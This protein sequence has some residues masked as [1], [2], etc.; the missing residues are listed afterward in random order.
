[1]VD[2]IIRPGIAYSFYA[3]PYSMPNIAKLDQKIIA[4][5]NAICS[6]PKSTPNITMR[7]PHDEFGLN[8][9]SLT[10]LTVYLTCIGKQLRNA[11]NDPRR[12]GT[13]YIGLTN[14]ILAKYSGSQHLPYSTKK[15][16]YTLQLLESSIY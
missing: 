14:Y 8:A 1:M 12:L 4:L 10:T 15:H 13:I 5:Q 7:L 2:T 6:F 3:V 9:L 11:L 16:V